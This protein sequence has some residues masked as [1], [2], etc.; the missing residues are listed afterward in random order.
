[1]FRPPPPAARTGV[2]PAMAGG[3]GFAA[4]RGKGRPGLGLFTPDSTVVH[5]AGGSDAQE[6]GWAIAAGTAYLRAL[7]EAGFDVAE[8]ARRIEF[9]LAVN[10]DQFAG[11]A[12]LRAVRAMWNQVLA[13]SGV[14]AD[15]RTM[16]VHATTSE[17][18]LTRHDPHVNMLRTT[19]AT[20]A[21][22]V[23][24]ADAVTVEP[25]D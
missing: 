18:M 10:A 15:Q 23:G 1:G 22:G 13:A 24:G 9:R 16:R 20:F 11:I 7:N 12:K 8:A 17:A 2:S 25:F 6:L 5:N 4:G 19:V 3:A 21:A 14:P